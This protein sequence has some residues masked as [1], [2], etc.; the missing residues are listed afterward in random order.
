MRIVKENDETKRCVCFCMNYLYVCVCERE[1]ERVRAR[2]ILN[3]YGMELVAK[4][5]I[6]SF[7]EAQNGTLSSFAYC[8]DIIFLISIEV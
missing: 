2:F 6:P 3:P 7:D 4:P 1:R 8:R 5:L